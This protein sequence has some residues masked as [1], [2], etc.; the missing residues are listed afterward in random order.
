[1]PPKLNPWQCFTSAFG[2]RTRWTGRVDRRRYNWFL[3]F[4]FICLIACSWLFGALFLLVH[5]SNLSYATQEGCDITL[6]FM[7]SSVGLVFLYYL[8]KMAE[9]KAHDRGW[10]GKSGSFLGC[11]ITVTIIEVIKGKDILLPLA[12]CG[13]F[14]IFYFAFR[15]V[16]ASFESMGKA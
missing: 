10:S 16:S 8:F 15:S 2:K 5:C 4:L 1:M 3:L 13:I 6:G 12:L 14:L 11:T 9:A 7:A